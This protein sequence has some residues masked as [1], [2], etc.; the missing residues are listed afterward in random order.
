MGSILAC[1]QKTFIFPIDF[2]DFIKLWG[3]LGVTLGSLWDTFVQFGA[4][5]GSPW[6]HFGS[7]W[8]HFGVALGHFGVKSGSDP[9]LDGSMC[10][11]HC[12]TY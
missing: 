3:Q 12:K 9:I 4:T 7:L 10:K 2:N 1:F 5:L 6:G 11:N 8:G